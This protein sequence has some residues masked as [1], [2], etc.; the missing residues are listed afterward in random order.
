MIISMMISIKAGEESRTTAARIPI[1]K[2]PGGDI[3]Y[4]YD[5]EHDDRGKY[6]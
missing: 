5:H 1:N 2:R 4:D 3:D 6:Q